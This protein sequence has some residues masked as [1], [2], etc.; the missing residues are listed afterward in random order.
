MVDS[1]NDRYEALSKHDC[2]H[3]IRNRIDRE[4]EDGN[5]EVCMTS[6]SINYNDF[7]TN[8]ILKKATV[9]YFMDHGYYIKFDDA[10]KFITIS[11]VGN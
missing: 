8:K 5:F 2:F 10:N 7:L 4:V 11:W 3:L 6:N 1:R 9:N